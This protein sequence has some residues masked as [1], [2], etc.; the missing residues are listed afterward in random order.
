MRKLPEEIIVN[1][2][3]PFIYMP[4]NNT[5]LD[6]VRSF[7][8]DMRFLE[9]LYYTDFNDTIL[10]YDLVRFCNCGLTSN[11]INPSFERILR[12]NPVLSK[13][14]SAYIVSYILSSFV[15]SVTYNATTKIKFIWTLLSPAERTSF[16][17]RVLFHLER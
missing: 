6:D 17:N 10:V 12:R 5:L 2:I 14:P 8:M 7:Y 15:T 3:A 1:H 11:G 9:N 13:K 16:I 4:Q